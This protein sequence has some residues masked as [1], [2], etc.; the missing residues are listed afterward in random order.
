MTLA[1]HL[2]SEGHMWTLEELDKLIETTLTGNIATID[3]P[4][5]GIAKNDLTM[6]GRK[7]AWGNRHRIDKTGVRLKS[8]H[9]MG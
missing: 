1:E 8:K 5:G 2:L 9:S 7:K 6:G 3:K 4:M